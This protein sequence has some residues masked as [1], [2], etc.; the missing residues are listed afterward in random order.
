MLVKNQN[1]DDFLKVVITQHSWLRYCVGKLLSRNKADEH[2][3]AAVEN[4]I[5]MK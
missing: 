2:S 4:L 1:D 3:F 5:N